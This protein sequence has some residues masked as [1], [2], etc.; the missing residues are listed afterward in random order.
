MKK[1]IFKLL[2][3]LL[4]SCTL[5]GTTVAVQ[6]EENGVE[7]VSGEAA[8]SAGSGGSSSIGGGGGFSG[9]GVGGGSR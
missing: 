7:M 2:T 8:R 6:A 1:K 3:G 4:L 9:G 5:V